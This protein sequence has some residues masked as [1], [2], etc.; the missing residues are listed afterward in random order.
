M[1]KE[2]WEEAAV[3]IDLSEIAQDREPMF[4]GGKHVEVDIENI[5]SKRHLKVLK[6]IIE[7]EMANNNHNTNN[8]NNLDYYG[9]DDDNDKDENDDDK[10]DDDHKENHHKK[11]KL[12][13]NNNCAKRF[14][15]SSSS[16]SS[17][18]KITTK[19]TRNK[20]K[21]EKNYSDFRISVEVMPSLVEHLRKLQERLTEHVNELKII[22]KQ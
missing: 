9:D 2:H 8:T 14:S 11:P 22:A 16:S 17:S 10:D 6:R 5:P 12:M 21:K 13:F 4:G 18:S 15:L 20:K 19:T 3:I 1:F 7:K